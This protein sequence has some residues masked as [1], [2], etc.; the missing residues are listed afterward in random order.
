M[1]RASGKPVIGATVTVARTD[2][3]AAVDQ[4]FTDDAGEC[5]FQLTPG[6]YSVSVVKSSFFIDTEGKMQLTLNGRQ[7]S[8]VQVNLIKGGVIAGRLLDPE[9]N[10]L[11]DIP[12]TAQ[13][14]DIKSKSTAL[15]S[16]QESNVTAISDDR[17]VFRIHGL[18]P[19]DYVIVVNARRDF[20]ARKTLP[21]T[22]YPNHRSLQSAVPLRVEA[23][24]EVTLPEMFIGDVAGYSLSLAGSV[25]GARR[26]PLAGASVTL[27]QA[28]N[29]A[30]SDATLTNADGRFAFDGLNP[31]RYKVRVSLKNGAYFSAEK[32]VAL[33]EGSTGNIIIELTEYPIIKGVAYF[34][35]DNKIEPL[36]DLA[37]SLVSIEGGEEIKFVSDENGEFSTKVRRDGL[38]VWQ[39]PKLDEHHYLQRITVG[40]KDVTDLPLKLDQKKS[41]TDV[42]VFVSRGGGIIEG[43]FEKS[44]VDGC[45]NFAVYAVAI[46]ALSNKSTLGFK[47][48]DVCTGNSFAVRSLAPGGYHLVA[49]PLPQSNKTKDRKSI[50]SLGLGYFYESIRTA[51]QELQL[52]QDD[53]ITVENYSQYAKRTPIILRRKPVP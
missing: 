36:P 8:A 46:E 38:F 21:T 34:S 28:S 3:G 49:L 10:A 50:P 7:S 4:A 20:S 15:P 53:I 12:V 47:R 42:S 11:T 41:I 13:K 23:S 22:Y 30:M 40:G 35:H 5:A 43:Q 14:M 33:A 51:I 52:K 16:P 19:G 39:F 44:I 24:Q 18:R 1:V 48:A 27:L 29:E 45:R 25:F 26:A 2:N 17:G 6:A 32:D 31:G 9:G 37:F